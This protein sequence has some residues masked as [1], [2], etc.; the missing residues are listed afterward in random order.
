MERLETYQLARQARVLPE[1]AAGFLF[2]HA[3]QMLPGESGVDDLDRNTLTLLRRYGQDDLAD[4][5]GGDRL[6]FDRLYERGRQFF[7]GPPDEEFAVRLRE[8]GIID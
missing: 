3:G 4:L 5:F 1:E 7:H 6:G 8:R 2:G